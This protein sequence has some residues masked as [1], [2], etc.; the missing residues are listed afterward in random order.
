[1]PNGPGGE[2]PNRFGPPPRIA[3]SSAT[4]QFGTAANRAVSGLGRERIGRETAARIPAKR[5]KSILRRPAETGCSSM[6]GMAF[7]KLRRCNL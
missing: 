5:Q 2:P 6:Q 7:P 3:R 1:M 4:N